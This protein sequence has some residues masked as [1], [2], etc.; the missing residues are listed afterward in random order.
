M[1]VVMYLPTSAL[2]FTAPARIFVLSFALP[3]RLFQAR[4]FATWNPKCEVDA[5]GN[6][7]GFTGNTRLSRLQG[8]G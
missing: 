3:K 5:H 4:F 1:Q 6:Q 7:S 8:K 2:P